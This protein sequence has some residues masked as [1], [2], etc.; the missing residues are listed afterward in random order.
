[1]STS[2]VEKRLGKALE[3]AKWSYT[4]VMH[5]DKY[6]Q[7]LY[8]D[9]EIIQYVRHFAPSY[10]YTASVNNNAASKRTGQNRKS[11]VKA[12]VAK[13]ASPRT[14]TR[15]GYVAD[16]RGPG[17]YLRPGPGDSLV[18]DPD[19]HGR[20]DPRDR[21]LTQP[22]DRIGDA[23][24]I[25]E[26]LPTTYLWPYDVDP[27]QWHDMF[28]N[29]LS[30]H[31]ESNNPRKNTKEW[32]G[33]PHCPLETSWE[34]KVRVDVRRGVSSTY[35]VAPTAMRTYRKTSFWAFANDP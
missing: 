31:K 21:Y 19:E 13:H 20:Y 25:R 23:N 6:L 14:E 33:H 34:V 11:S 4:D 17:V 12:A 27:S 16:T 10:G 22:R 18:H 9:E 1:M 29:W 7:D 15:E 5:L 3:D 30:Q 28:L 24:V 35:T 26:T 32:I 8:P 2:A